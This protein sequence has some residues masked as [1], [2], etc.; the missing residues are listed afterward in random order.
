MYMFIENIVSFNAPAKALTPDPLPG[1]I[2]IKQ[3]NQ[4]FLKTH[5]ILAMKLYRKKQLPCTKH[6]VLMQIPVH[7]AIQISCRS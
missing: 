2:I 1:W 5:S 4:D 7:A 6:M 3:S